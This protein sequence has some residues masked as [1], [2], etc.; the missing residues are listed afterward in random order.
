MCTFGKIKTQGLTLQ[1]FNSFIFKLLLDLGFHPSLVQK[2]EFMYFQPQLVCKYSS[3]FIDKQTAPPI[4][5]L[6]A[7]KGLQKKQVRWEDT[8][9]KSASQTVE[10]NLDNVMEIQHLCLMY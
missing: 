7:I 10:T 4:L 6:G 2:S 1:R 3:K 8:L 5:Q 9:D